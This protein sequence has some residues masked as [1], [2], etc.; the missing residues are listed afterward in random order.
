MKLKEMMYVSL[1]AAIVAALGLLP[2]IALPFT[3]VPITAQ[4]I[5]VM[6]AGSVLGARLGGL[7]LG[8]FV[9]LV[10]A[11]APILSGGRGGIGILAGP[12]GGYILSWPIAAFIIGF[13]AEKFWDR[14]KLWNMIVFNII[15]GIFVIYLCGV[16]F[17]SIVGD[18]TWMQAAT[19]A[20]IYLPGDIVKIVLTS[21][22][23]IRIK[24]SYPLIKTNRDQDSK[25]KNANLT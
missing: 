18:F 10:A 9:L 25:I 3:P 16:T 14:L 21:M 8:L 1:F 24:K 15:G 19:S 20:L 5:G 11:G 2:P 7:S 17:L 13:L 22:I 4:T 12:S 6:L 23:A